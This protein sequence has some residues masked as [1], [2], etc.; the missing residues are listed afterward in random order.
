MYPDHISVSHPVGNPNSYNAAIAFNEVHRLSCFHTCLFGPFGLKRRYHA[1]LAVAKV[2]T[3]PLPEVVRLMLSYLPIKA[4]NGR[5]P[6]M[7]Y[8]LSQQFDKSVSRQID[9]DSAVYCYEDCCLETFKRAKSLGIRR[10]YELPIAHYMEGHLNLTEESRR[11]PTLVPM[12]S[13][14]K[15]PA[16]KFRRKDQ[17][18]ET[19]SMIVCASNYVKR[20]I[21]NHHGRITPVYVVPYGADVSVPAKVWTAG[22]ESGPLRLLYVGMLDPRKGIHYMFEALARIDPGEYHLTLAGRW[23]DGFREWLDARFK[24]NYIHI[25]QMTLRDLY[26]IYRRNHLFLFPTLHEGFGLVLLEALASGIP[27]AATERCGAP[28]IMTDGVE[29]FWFHSADADSLYEMLRRALNE[30][31][32]LPEMGRA[33]RLLAERLTWSAY[34]TRLAKT[35]FAQDGAGGA[36]EGV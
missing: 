31:R 4:F 20:S 33:A 23:K 28:D 11:H 5:S 34:R 26:P 15:E 29:G 13:G 32:R 35:I 27:V 3:H 18:L 17:E 36:I 14:L 24:V 6:T 12:M 1:D 22:D 7:T 21:E 8:W 16:S 2:C 30:R 10:I 25:G 9:K 19:A